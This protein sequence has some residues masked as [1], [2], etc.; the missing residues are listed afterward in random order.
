MRSVRLASPA[1]LGLFALVSSLAL[2]GCGAGP[3][4]D[5]SAAA[6]LAGGTN[7]CDAGQRFVPSGLSV[8]PGT[9][10]WGTHVGVVVVYP[11]ALADGHYWALGVDQTTTQVYWYMTGA[12]KADI[13]K[14]ESYVQSQR[15]CGG[16]ANPGS[17]S[18]PKGQ[19]DPQ[20]TGICAPS[21]LANDT[22]WEYLYGPPGA[23]YTDYCALDGSGCTL[24]TCSSYSPSC[25]YHSNG[26]G[27]TIYCGA[28]GSCPCGGVY[29][30]CYVCS[31]F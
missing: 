6:L 24:R 30:R 29:P 26:C 9:N 28:C 5:E 17:G 22:T 15:L 2:A 27:T 10:P 20:L 19:P 1:V 13:D 12:S 16:N 21:T 31:T 18:S 25:G 8:A 4:G 3:T 14:L 23:P 11:D 7:P